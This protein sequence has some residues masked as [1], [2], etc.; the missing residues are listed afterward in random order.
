[1]ST[2]P[3]PISTE[4]PP[5]QCMH[6]NSAG[7]LHCK[8]GLRPGALYCFLHDPER[9]EEAA[10]ARR[11]GGELRNSPIMPAAPCDLST[12]EAQRRV[13]EETINRLRARQEPVQIARTVI[14]AVSTARAI[15]DQEQLLARLEALE[16]GQE[17]DGTGGGQVWLPRYREPMY[18][19][20]DR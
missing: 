7:Q 18:E 14:Y 19:E 6:L 9:A 20:H 8:A 16:A 17:A 1:M 2:T 4:A 13:L 3:P 15:L 5:S 11:K 10:E 12:A